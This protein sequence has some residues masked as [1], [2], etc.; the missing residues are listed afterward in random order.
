MYLARDRHQSTGS[1]L[2]R[3]RRFVPGE[4]SHAALRRRRRPVNSQTTVNS[5]STHRQ[6]NLPSAQRQLNVSAPSN[7]SQ[8]KLN[9]RLV[10]HGIYRSRS[11]Q[12][13]TSTV[14]ISDVEVCLPD[15]LAR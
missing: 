6:L 12:L 4:T 2:A 3:T 15:I 1:A 7:H 9:S 14:S 10:E 11:I 13:C 8:I 5:Q